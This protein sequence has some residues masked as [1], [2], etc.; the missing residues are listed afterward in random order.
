MLRMKVRLDP[1]GM[2]LKEPRIDEVVAIR[3]SRVLA[4]GLLFIVCFRSFVEIF[5]RVVF[6]SIGQEIENLDHGLV[7]RRP[8][9]DGLGVMDA[10]TVDDQK[11]LLLRVLDESLQ[12]IDED[13]Y[14]QSASLTCIRPRLLAA[15]MMLVESFCPVCATIRVCPFGS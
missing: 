7:V 1:V 6:G 5:I 2:F 4:R 10:Q 3:S 8:L 14:V 12:K 13:R 15:A 9:P 11:D